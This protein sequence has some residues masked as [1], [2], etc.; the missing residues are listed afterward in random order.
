MHDIHKANA[1]S[2]KSEESDAP[3]IVTW[4][5]PNLEPHA[6]EQILWHCQKAGNDLINV[7]DLCLG[8]HRRNK[9]EGNRLPVG[10][11]SLP[12]HNTPFL[13]QGFVVQKKKEIADPGGLGCYCGPYSASLCSLDEFSDWVGALP[14]NDVSDMS[15]AISDHSCFFWSSF[16]WT[17]TRQRRKKNPG[18][19]I[20]NFQCAAGR[21]F[22]IDMRTE[23]AATDWDR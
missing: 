13:S 22:D 21:G 8:I 1:A 9:G 5:C 14:V 16:L 4:D 3:G 10:L 2:E 15:L 18:R 20:S 7:P 12:E 17:F 11:M 19:I 6:S 23:Q